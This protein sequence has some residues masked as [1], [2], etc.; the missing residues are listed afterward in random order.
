MIADNHAVLFV[1]CALL[2]SCCCCFVCFLYECLKCGSRWWDV[3]E[4]YFW[5]T[6][7]QSAYWTAIVQRCGLV[8]MYSPPALFDLSFLMCFL[9]ISCL[10]FICFWLSFWSHCGCIWFELAHNPTAWGGSLSLSL[11][12]FFFLCTVMKK[13][14]FIASIWL[15]MPLREGESNKTLCF[16][17][18]V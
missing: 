11:F 4:R 2:Q 17:E 14:L 15:L 18:M 9:F 6:C 7:S 1:H 16:C 8:V 10:T 12:V 5:Y 13:I 3:F